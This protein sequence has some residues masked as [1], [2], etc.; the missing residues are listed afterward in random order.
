M[1]VMTMNSYRVLQ[2]R[3]AP[4][5]LHPAQLARLVSLHGAPRYLRSDNGPEFVSTAVMRWLLDAKID[6]A[7]IAP[8]PFAAS[9]LH[10]GEP[11]KNEGPDPRI[12]PPNPGLKLERN[13]RFELATFALAILTRR[14]T[15]SPTGHHR[16]PS[17]RSY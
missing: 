2:S 13:T 11:A 4:R 1:A 10:A 12:S 5:S 9:L 17:I 16:H 6:A 14:V 15:A 8:T 7:H 3:R